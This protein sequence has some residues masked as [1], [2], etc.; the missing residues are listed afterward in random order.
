MTAVHL[1]MLDI[2]EKLPNYNLNFKLFSIKY[3]LKS[4]VSYYGVDF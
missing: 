1:F 3:Q 4:L 2:M